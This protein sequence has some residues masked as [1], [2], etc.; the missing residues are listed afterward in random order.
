[1]AIVA[2][3]MLNTIFLSIGTSVKVFGTVPETGVSSIPPVSTYSIDGSSSSTFAPTI[4]KVPVHKMLYYQSPP[5][6][7]GEHTLVITSL[8][9][10]SYFWLDYFEVT[11][12]ISEP[13]PPIL[14]PDIITTNVV[15]ITIPPNPSPSTPVTP[16]EPKDTT[17]NL[18]STGAKPR[19]SNSVDSGKPGSPPD[20]SK[21]PDASKTP[22]Y[23]AYEEPSGTSTPLVASG[24]SQVPTGAIVGGVMGGVI[25]FL[26]I[27]FLIWRCRRKA[28]ARH[29]HAHIET[30]ALRSSFLSST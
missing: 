2:Q 21:P 13:P 14:P 30:T 16:D 15:V 4:G 19:P 8:A 26:I 5:L 3:A 25:V 23:S 12:S 9:K 24:S 17:T 7:D 28:N 27:I 29:A 10:D 22:L 18:P 11:P 1:M 20:T 6:Q